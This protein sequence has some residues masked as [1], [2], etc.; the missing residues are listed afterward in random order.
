MAR[1]LTALVQSH[2]SNQFL[3]QLQQTAAFTEKFSV[4]DQMGQCQCRVY[5]LFHC[6]QVAK[7]IHQ[8]CFK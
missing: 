4:Q 6:P 8:C 1:N 2:C 7:E 5:S 3:F